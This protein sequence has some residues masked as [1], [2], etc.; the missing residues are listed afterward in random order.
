MICYLYMV[1]CIDHPNDREIK[2]S[3]VLV[4]FSYILYSFYSLLLFFSFY[5]LIPFCK[6]LGIS[7]VK[8][9]PPSIQVVQQSSLDLAND[10]LVKTRRTEKEGKEEESVS[11]D[12]RDRCQ[13]LENKQKDSTAEDGC[14]KKREVVEEKQFAEVRSR[15]R[16][17]EGSGMKSSLEEVVR[18]SY[19][20]ETL[21][22]L[23]RCPTPNPLPNPRVMGSMSATPKKRPRTSNYIDA[24]SKEKRQYRGSKIAEERDSEELRIEQVH[25]VCRW[26]TPRA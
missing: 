18:L 24:V 2:Y 21:E 22:E 4:S 23:V 10:V 8:L 14:D 15:E 13:K 9:A 11:L 16:G 7:V 12:E 19:P 25:I 5:V 3:N 26:G 20:S 6:Q 17:G 1:L